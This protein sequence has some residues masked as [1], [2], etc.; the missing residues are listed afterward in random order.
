MVNKKLLVK[1]TAAAAIR[2]VVDILPLLV[3]L[4]TTLLNSVITFH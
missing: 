4:A 1:N 3:F 2:A